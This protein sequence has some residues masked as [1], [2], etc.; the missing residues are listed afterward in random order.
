MRMANPRPVLRRNDMN[1]VMIDWLPTC[2][3]LAHGDQAPFLSAW[4]QPGGEFLC[5]PNGR[6]LAPSDAGTPRS[7]R[8]L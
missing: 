4:G 3:V 6:W 7:G 2:I 8:H 1:V 5:P